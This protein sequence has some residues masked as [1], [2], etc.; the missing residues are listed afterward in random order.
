MRC[1]LA[2]TIMVLLSLCLPASQALPAQESA[3]PLPGVFS[4]VL[5]VRVVNLE[6]VV[7]DKDGVPVRGLRPQDFILRVDGEEIAIEY[8]SEIRNGVAAPRAVDESGI[9]VAEIPAILAGEPVETSYLV[10]ID[11]FFA[12]ARDRDR[13]VAALRKQ[14][15]RLGPK[16]RMAIV[17][18]NGKEL[19]MLT[20]WSQSV[21]ALDRVLEDAVQRPTHGL[22]RLAEQR[23]F[24][25][26]RIL[27]ASSRIRDG[28]LVPGQFYRTDLTPLERFYLER[29]SGQ[30][31]QTVTA[32][33]STLRSFAMPPGR[34]VMLLFSGGWPFFPLTFI[35]P[36]ISPIAV[37]ERTETGADL[38]RPLTDTANLL[39]YTLYPVDM[40]G[41]DDLLSEDSGRQASGLV[42]EPL[43]VGSLLYQNTFLRQQEVQYTL[44]FLARE[45]GGLALINAGRIEAFDRAV[46]DTRSYYWLGF[47]PDREWDNRRHDVAIELRQDGFR[48]R[49]RKDFLDVSRQHEVTMA[50]ESSLLFGSPPGSQEL[51]L[52]IGAPRRAGRKRMEVPLSV[53]IPLSEVTFLPAGEEQVTQLELRVLVRDEDGGRAEVPAVPL[54]IRAE[55]GPGAKSMGRFDTTL[56]LRRKRHEAVVGVY[57]PASGRILSA[58]AQIV[59]E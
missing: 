42:A 15:P 35:G 20:S 27:L 1:P 39:G 4:E 55:E 50:L 13:V 49:S 25:F 59:P 9:P 54:Q 53:L 36:Y 24:D 58:S 38:F 51:E 56:K 5:D 26:D 29:L 45:T 16:D 17:A 32:A 6:V 41:F 10:F 19:E 52:D 33:M 7:T 40:P 31:Q 57:D 44:D 22:E 21:P 8:F 28:L 23:Q 46:S 11:E 34:K 37:G 12:I 14:L 2:R 43:A 48:V 47:T 3:S 18:Y 30:I